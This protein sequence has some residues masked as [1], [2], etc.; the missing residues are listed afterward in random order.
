MIPAVLILPMLMAASAPK[1]SSVVFLG[2]E[3]FHRWSMNG[4]NEYTPKGS[5][6]LAAWSNMLTLN[7]TSLDPAHLPELASTIRANYEKAGA[8]VLSAESVEGQTGKTEYFQAA[9]FTTPAFMEAALTRVFLV[10][11]RP[12][13]A[14]Y[15]KRFYGADVSAQMSAWLKQN[16]TP[17]EKSLR[18]WTGA[19]TRKALE[20]LPQSTK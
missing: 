20:A 16:R 8:T 15:A 2:E 13:I 6:D 5:E 10:E 12:L 14:T 9:V 3:Y 17:I 18:T 7:P 11:G 4:Q 1:P 19:P